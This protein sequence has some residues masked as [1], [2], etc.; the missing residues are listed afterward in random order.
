MNTSGLLVVGLCAV[1]AAACGK[2]E[3]PLNPSAGGGTLTAPAAA[4]PGDG[5]QLASLRPTLSVS[6]SPTT[7]AGTRS[8]EFQV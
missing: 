7:T 2:T 6:N 1:G 5:A 3:A 8:Y 4:S